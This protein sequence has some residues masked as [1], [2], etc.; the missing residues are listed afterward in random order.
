MLLRAL[1]IGVLHLL[2]VLGCLALSVG[3]AMQGLDTGA[4]PSFLARI[5]LSV[6]DVLLLPVARPV[7]EHGTANGGGWVYLALAINSLVWGLILAWLT[8]LSRRRAMAGV[9]RLRSRGNGGHPRRT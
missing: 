5:A 4:P 3:A 6:G 1:L 2:I 9:T 8:G 7:F